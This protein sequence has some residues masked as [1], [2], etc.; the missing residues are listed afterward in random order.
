MCI[1]GYVSSS[2]HE[3]KDFLCFTQAQPAPG[4]TGSPKQH[5]WDPR[6]SRAQWGRL[7]YKFVFLNTHFKSWLPLPLA[8][9]NSLIP[10]LSPFRPLTQREKQT[11]N[12]ITISKG[13]MLPT[14]N[15]I[16]VAFC[17]AS[18]SDCWFEQEFSVRGVNLECSVVPYPKA[19]HG[20]GL[21]VLAWH[22]TIFLL[23]T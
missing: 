1:L 13:N 7:F 23:C 19:L 17:F 10:H 12:Q 18:E 5:T 8:V 20:L 15:C 2:V 9:K 21:P 6:L 16:G 3:K 4:R 11:L 14:I 22:G